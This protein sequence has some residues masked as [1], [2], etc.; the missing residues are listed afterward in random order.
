MINS[1]K[2]PILALILFVFG[3]GNAFAENKVVVIP[4]ASD[5]PN[6]YTNSSTGFVGIGTDTP[7]N[8]YTLF[9]VK[10]PTTNTWG[11][12]YTSTS[13]ELGRPFYGYTADGTTSSAWHEYNG[14]TDEW[15]LYV[16]GGV[17][18][19]SVNT[20]GDIAQKLTSDG[21]VKAAVFADCRNL[22]ASI[23]RSFNNVNGAAISISSDT[24]GGCT[25]D[26]GF[27]ISDRFWSPT[28]VHATFARNVV[29][30]RSSSSNNKLDCLRTTATGAAANGDIIV[31]IY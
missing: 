28:G 8:S 24:N 31:L 9:S 19:I 2:A 13:G 27:D 10:S 15:Q 7:L 11:G 22:V 17:P 23:D 29:C 20:S 12:M 25:I 4:M 14:V 1:V 30:K 5:L 21:L 26:F 16:D 18:A 3:I 6:V